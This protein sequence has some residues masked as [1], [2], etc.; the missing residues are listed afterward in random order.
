MRTG[1][2][3]ACWCGAVL[4][5]AAPVSAHANA[6]GLLTQFNA[7][8]F[9]S[10]TSSA[11][12]EGRTVVGGDM[13]GGATFALNP[14]SGTSSY[15][16]LT[17]YGNETSSGN[18]NID[19][20]GGL[21]IQGSNN[22]NFNLNGGGSAFV[23][24]SN[25]GSIGSS[26]GG[27]ASIGVVGAN[28]GRLS[29][30]SGGSVTVGG[31]NSGNGQITVGGGQGTINVLGSNNAQLT[32]N[33]GGSVYV[34]PGNAG[35]VSVGGGSANVAVN[36]S[37]T[38]Q[39]T[40]NSSATVQI[41]GDTGNVSMSG[42]SLTYAGNVTGNINANGATVT[43]DPTLSVTAPAA[44]SNTLP[45]FSSTFQN[46]LVQL[47]GQLGKLNPNS[48]VVAGINHETL[49]ASP[50]SSGQ[51]VLDIT[52]G[53]FTPN[54]TFDIALNGASSFIIN[55]AISGCSGGSGCAL[56][57]PS[58]LNFDNPTSYASKVLWNFIDATSL[59]FPNEFGGTVLSPYASVTNSG[60]I[61]G[62]LVAEQ[63]T[64]R[65][66]L[67]SYPFSGS[68]TTTG[69]GSSSGSPV[70]EPSSLAMMASGLALIVGWRSRGR[71]GAALRTRRRR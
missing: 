57:L 43:H 51:A 3:I 15:S 20:G 36:G 41:K 64:G 42:G 6:I 29:L 66:E 31:S 53:L 8:V 16:A 39:I 45:S 54:T 58:S 46:S 22:G 40:T 26:G 30:S 11:D 2:S 67:H 21:T 71:W 62:T 12:V 70:P 27:S 18:F 63:Y 61:D 60:P 13:T 19:Q 32:L 7:I 47:S 25:A 33:N 52:S 4:A 14:L 69:S 65:G 44:P 35:N 68:I 9:G 23:G 37:N 38:A 56:S 28:T 17:V 59:S 1:G 24:G 49:S 5:L 34:G 10:F 48:S 55:V 50:D